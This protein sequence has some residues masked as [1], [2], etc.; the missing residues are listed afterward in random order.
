MSTRCEHWYIQYDNNKDIAKKGDVMIYLCY[1]I[2]HALVVNMHTRTQTQTQTHTHTYIYIYI[3]IYTPR[4]H[5]TVAQKDL[6]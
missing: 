3:Y 1:K 5:C 4:D 2:M 6:F